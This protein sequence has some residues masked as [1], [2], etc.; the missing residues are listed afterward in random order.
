MWRQYGSRTAQ[1][2]VPDDALAMVAG[3]FAASAAGH[4][5]ASLLAITSALTGVNRERVQALLGLR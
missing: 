1:P 3:D 2:E 5:S 4:D